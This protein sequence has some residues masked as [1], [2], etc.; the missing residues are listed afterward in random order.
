VSHYTT[1]GKITRKEQFLE[2]M[3]RIIPWTDLL[4]IVERVWYNKKL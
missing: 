2:E 1:G 3:E 4:L